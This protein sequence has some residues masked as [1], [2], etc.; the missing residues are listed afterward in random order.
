M[1][2]LTSGTVTLLAAALVVGCSG[3]PTGDLRNGL[4]ELTASPSTLNVTLGKNKTTLITAV[5]SQGNQITT[6]FEVTDVGPGI[7]VRR[8]SSYLPIYVN[9]STLSVPPEAPAFQ[10]I[11]SATGLESTHF[12]VAVGDK[13]V[14]IPV[15]VAP[16]PLNVPISTLVA[17]GTSIDTTTITAPTGFIFSP[18]AFVTF[19]A[20]QAATLGVSGDG[21]QLFINAPPGATSKGTVTGLIVPYFPTAIVSDSTDAAV[22]MGAIPPARPGT[23][24]ISTAPEIAFPSVSGARTGIIDGNGGY[25]AANCGGNSGV[26]CQLYKIVVPADATID[27]TLTWSNDADMGLYVLNA[28]GTDADTGPCDVDGRAAGEPEVCDASGNFGAPLVFTAGTYYLAAVNFGPF[29]PENDPNPD[30]IRIDL[31]AE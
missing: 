10:Y 21:T 15:F 24:D 28:D 2:R 29:Y 12:T 23:D 18:S 20:G 16:D 22:T 26:P 11:V 9:D 30:W 4:S 19:D 17:G 25:A 13:N 3:D 5:D 1:N 27:A 31:V 6:A 8:D 14:T 7:S